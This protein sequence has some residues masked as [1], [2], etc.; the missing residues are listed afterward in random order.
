MNE[1]AQIAKDITVALISRINIPSKE[2]QEEWVSSTAKLVCDLYEEVYESV[3][4]ALD[5]RKLPKKYTDSPDYPD[6]A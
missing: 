6:L 2:T 1:A 3:K 4:R 5:S